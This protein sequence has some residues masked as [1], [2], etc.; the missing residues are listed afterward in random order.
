MLC[1]ASI[2]ENKEERDFNEF[3][4]FDKDFLDSKKY[5]SNH[6]L[7]EDFFSMVCQNFRK[8]DDLFLLKIE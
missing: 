1:N 2:S 8:Y 6:S 4:H 7:N 3:S 5:F